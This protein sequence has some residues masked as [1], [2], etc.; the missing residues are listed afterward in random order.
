MQYPY[1]RYRIYYYAAVNA[2]VGPVFIKLMS[3]TVGQKADK[4]WWKTNYKEGGWGQITSCHPLA[5]YDRVKSMNTR[6]HG[7]W[8]TAHAR[9]M[10]I[11]HHEQSWWCNLITPLTCLP[12]E[13][14]TLRL[15]RLSVTCCPL[16]ECPWCEPW[17]LGKWCSPSTMMPRP[18]AGKNTSTSPCHPGSTLHSVM[19]GPRA[20]SPPKHA[21]SLCSHWEGT[22]EPPDMLILACAARIEGL[23][24]ACIAAVVVLLKARWQWH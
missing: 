8:A 22:A 24:G 16:L 2:L 7:L 15:K 19:M 12:L 1:N 4:T 6:T 18:K 10:C 21:Y 9:M 23:E 5:L 17:W 11:A 20:G 14:S 3:G 13:A